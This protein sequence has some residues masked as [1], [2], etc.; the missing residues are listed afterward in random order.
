MPRNSQLCDPVPGAATC[1]VS[2]AYSQSQ[3]PPSAPNQRTLCRSDQLMTSFRST[4]AGLLLLLQAVQHTSVD[5][6]SAAAASRKACAVF[7]RRLLPWRHCTTVLVV[8]QPL[9][10]SSSSTSTST[11]TSIG[12]A[13]PELLD[14]RAAHTIYEKARFNRALL[15]LL[16]MRSNTTTV[17]FAAPDPATL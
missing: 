1:G 4:T 3:I 10:N 14:Y 15:H 8:R 9:L 12:A 2:L 5:A 16:C 17:D 13:L 6:L 7:T 11:S